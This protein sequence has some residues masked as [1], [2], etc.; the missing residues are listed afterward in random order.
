MI[1]FLFRGSFQEHGTGAA[2]WGLLRAFWDFRKIR[3]MTAILL[4]QNLSFWVAKAKPLTPNMKF[5]EIFLR[6]K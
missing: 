4:E 2:Y 3:Y 1:Y 5:I 6:N